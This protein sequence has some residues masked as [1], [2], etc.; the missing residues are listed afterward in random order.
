MERLK[1]RIA[2]ADKAIATLESLLRE[3]GG[4]TVW[5]DACIKRFEYSVETTWKA[6]QRYLALEGTD[7]A[8]PK[9]VVRAC[10]QAG[11]LTETEAEAAL[12]LIDDRNLAAHTYDEKLA[13]AL[14]SRLRAHAT[15]L[16]AWLSAIRARA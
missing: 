10:F 8:S 13:N 15:L 16:R 11:L 12:L 6:A 4:T 7:L 1:E 9:P 3:G 14:A 5:R 2:F